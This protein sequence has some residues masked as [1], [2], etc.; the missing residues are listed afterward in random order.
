M[1]FFSA[2]FG[3]LQSDSKVACGIGVTPHPTI[4]TDQEFGLQPYSGNAFRQKADSA[5]RVMLSLSA[6]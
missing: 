6:C 1:A 2:G 3:Q 4:S 5:C